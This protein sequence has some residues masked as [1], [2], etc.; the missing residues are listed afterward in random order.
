[1]P[2]G[3][4][5]EALELSRRRAEE[6]A[7]DLAGLQTGRVL[8]PGAR[9]WRLVLTDARSAS[10]YQLCGRGGWH[11]RDMLLGLEL[12][13]PAQPTTSND[14]LLQ[15]ATDPRQYGDQVRVASVLAEEQL[16]SA[17]AALEPA[18]VE[19]AA[20]AVT[21]LVALAEARGCLPTRDA[22][23]RHAAAL[24]ALER[25]GLSPEAGR[26]VQARLDLTK[27]EAR[28]QVKGGAACTLPPRHV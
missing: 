7:A 16:R 13:L 27:H 21:E 26:Y 19:Q 3:V 18:A 22:E 12:E 17:A 24:V 23:E 5:G 15:E 14:V 1:M 28:A 8:A 25:L 11:T 4:L 9:A 2:A 6:Q 20:N 10:P